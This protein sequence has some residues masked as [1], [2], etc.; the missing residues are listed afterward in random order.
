MSRR[1]RPGLEPRGGSLT[2]IA[3]SGSG[4][5]CGCV[6]RGKVPAELISWTQIIGDHVCQFGTIDYYPD[7]PDLPTITE[8]TFFAGTGSDINNHPGR[9]AYGFD[10]ESCN[11]V[12]QSIN[13]TPDGPCTQEAFWALPD[14]PGHA[15]T[16][17]AEGDEVRVQGHAYP[18]GGDSID[19]VELEIRLQILDEFGVVDLQDEYHI[20]PLPNGGV[21]FDEVYTVPGAGNLRVAFVGYVASAQSNSVSLGVPASGLTISTRTP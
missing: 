20:G 18:R 7:Y 12:V 5:K 1:C 8:E 17:V 14:L 10:L 15:I 3:P 9:W 6:K 11:A 16:T 19:I 13:D 4:S 21:D 2:H